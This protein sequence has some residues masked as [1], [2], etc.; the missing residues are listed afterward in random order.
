MKQLAQTTDRAKRMEIMGEI[1]T[2][3]RRDTIMAHADTEVLENKVL[4]A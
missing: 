3:K 1:E 4:N 2:L